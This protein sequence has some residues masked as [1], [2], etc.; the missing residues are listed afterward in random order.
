MGIGQT[1]LHGY[2]VRD[3]TITA[4]TL[5]QEIAQVLPRPKSNEVF[6]SLR[7][8]T[9]MLHTARRLVKPEQMPLMNMLRAHRGIDTHKIWTF[10]NSP[11]PALPIL[12]NSLKEEGQLK[13]FRLCQINCFHSS[14]Q[15]RVDAGLSC[16]LFAYYCHLPSSQLHSL[17]ALS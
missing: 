8:L 9:D 2:G 10:C 11:S 13:W 14:A 6:E 4:E 12:L 1:H 3:C 7:A 17:A 15:G 16:L 5:V